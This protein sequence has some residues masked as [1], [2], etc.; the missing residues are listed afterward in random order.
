M[1][2]LIASGGTGGHIAPALAFREELRRRNIPNELLL[3]GL[4][5]RFPTGDHFEFSA[6]ELNLSGIPKIVKGIFQTFDAVN[7]AD[8][9]VGFGGY[10]QFPPI[11]NA[12]L[13]NKSIYLF[14]PDALPGKS[15]KFLS[16]FAQRVFCA[17]REATKYFKNGIFV[18]I[19]VRKLPIIKKEEAMK[20]L[21]IETSLPVVGIIGGSQGSEFLNGIARF[22]VNTGKFFVLAVVGKRGENE[23]GKNYK[24]VKF[25]EDIS[26]FYCSS[27]VLISRAGMSS[28]G[29]IAYFKKPALLIP[30]PYAG[31]H[32]VFNALDLYNFGG[33]EMLLENDARG[34]TVLEILEKLLA[35]SEKYK[36]KLEEYFLPDAER[37]MA[38]YILSP[39]FG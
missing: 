8:V 36:K 4:K 25:F 11:L 1:R 37:V 14:E 12:I 35:N 21:K 18:G 33:A 2:I 16:P 15:N 31:G 17:F 26:L 13:N 7:N 20:I 30:Y 10:P 27:D 5:V 29:E 32:Q 6:G 28:I 39:A 22:L 3:G 19:P 34:D 9:V 24:F 23:E 38:D